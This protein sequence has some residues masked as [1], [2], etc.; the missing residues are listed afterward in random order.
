L[1]AVAPR[2]LDQRLPMVTAAVEAG[3]K[4]IYCEKPF[5]RSLAEADE[6]LAACDARGVK[7]AVA[8]QNRAFP[9][10]GLAQTLLAAGKIGRLRTM[11]AFTKHDERGGGL[12]LLLHGT[13]LFDLMRFFA[14]EAHWCHARVTQD[15]RDVIAADAHLDD[16]GGLIAGDDVVAEYGFERGVIGWLESIRS[17]DGGGT[18]YFHLELG[19]TGG[20]LALWSS[21]S[22]P[23]L[24]YPRPFALPDAPD[25]W[26]I[27]QPEV[28]PLPEGVSAMHPANQE[29][30]ADLLA[31]LE[32]DRQPIASGHAA[33]AALEMIMGAYESHLTGHR[34]ALPLERREHPLAR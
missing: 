17:D 25:R 32:Q 23:V 18:P 27:V 7:L 33:R 30:V 34:V 12:E 20:V 26:E 2:W 31:A 11:R 22:S 9:A 29:L 15:G 14:G 28:A 5:A 24:H 16:E 3:V 6:M 4:A 21:L 8:H 13:H 19:G 10:P 1:V